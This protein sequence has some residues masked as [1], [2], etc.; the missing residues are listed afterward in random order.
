MEQKKII[1]F[2]R[3][4]RCHKPIGTLLLLWP[5]LWALWI[6]EAGFPNTTLLVVF[7]VGV[8]TMRAAGCVI[9]DIFD[10]QY[11]PK[12]LR[13]QDRPLAT[14]EVTVKSAWWFVGFWLLLSASLLF[15]LNP[16]TG[17]MAVMVVILSAIYPLSKRFFHCPQLVLGLT[18][19]LGTLMAF[20]ASMNRIPDVAWW[21][22]GACVVWTIAF[23]TEYAIVDREYDRKLGIQSSALWF[24]QYDKLAIGICQLIMLSILAYVGWWLDFAW[25]YGISLLVATMLTLYQQV[26]IKD[27]D[28]DKC[29]KAFLN[30]QW[31]GLAVFIGIVLTYWI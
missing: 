22:Y 25:P 28:P 26:L 17:K 31:I 8:F 10:R 1:V 2:A 21:I 27:R 15:W 9:N 11:D 4:A 14:G 30:N 12:V 3:L 29:F 6:A 13:T 16:L 18:F 7:C 19:Y 23:D 5:T 20:A 24:G